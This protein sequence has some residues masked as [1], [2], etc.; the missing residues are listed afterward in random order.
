MKNLKLIIPIV[1]I[2]ILIITYT[3]IQTGKDSIMPDEIY[4]QIEQGKQ[5]IDLTELTTMKWTEARA[6]GPYSTTKTIEESMGVN[7]LLG[8]IDVMETKFLLVFA[9]EG[10][11]V[12]MIYLDRKYGDYSI[13]DDQYL[14]VKRKIAK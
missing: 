9:K 11:V 7:F 1:V 8:G 5:K 4:A 12:D 14:F 13:K 3:L 10:K 6:F 2:G